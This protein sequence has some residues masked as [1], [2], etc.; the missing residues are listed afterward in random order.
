MG[1]G[2]G[3]GKGEEQV[4]T[5]VDIDELRNNGNSSGWIR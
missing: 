1:R 2:K 4:L 5:H 3:R